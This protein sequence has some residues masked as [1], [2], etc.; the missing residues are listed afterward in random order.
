MLLLTLDAFQLYGNAG[1]RVIINAVTTSKCIARIVL[2]PM[3]GESAE[4]DSYT[5]YNGGG[6]VL[7]HE[8]AK[9]GLDTIIIRDYDVN[10]AGKYNITFQSFRA[11]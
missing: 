6:D 11:L 3:D 10:T 2:Y 9:T 1:D 4:A 8:L 5:V 7:D